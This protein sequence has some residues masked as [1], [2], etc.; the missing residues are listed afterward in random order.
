MKYYG[1][2]RMKINYV[3]STDVLVIGGGGAG[4][5]A[6]IKAGEAGA[7]VLLVTKCRFGYTGA[8]FYPG[9]EGWGINAITHEGDSVDYFYDEIIEAGAGATDRKLAR[10]LVEQSTERFHEMENYG[11]EFGKDKNGRYNSVIS[12]FGK[13]VRGACANLEKIK[14]ALWEQMMK[15]GVRIRS[16]INI[17][18]LVVDNGLCIGAVGFDEMDA[19]MFINAKSTVIATGGG[20][21]LFKYSLATP[22]QT[23]DGYIMAIEAGARLANLEFIQFIPGLTWPTKKL[24]FQEKNLDTFPQIKNRFGED[25]LPKYLPKGITVEECL[26]ERAKHGPFTSA[27]ISKYFDIALYEEWQKG[28]VTN[29]GGIHFR[30]DSSVLDDERWIITSW[31]EWMKSRNVDVVHEGFD[32]IPHAQC[33]NG[34]IY[35]DENANVGIKGLFAA[36]ETAGGPHGADRLG[37]N[38]QAATQVYGAIAGINAAQWAKDRTLAK[39]DAVDIISRLHS[40]FDTGQGGVVDIDACISEIKEIMWQCGAIVRSEE[41]IAEGLKRISDLQ[42]SFNPWEHYTKNI[43]TKKASGLYSRINLSKI[44]LEVM[45]YRKESRGPHYRTDYPEKNSAFEGMIT[46]KKNGEGISLEL[47]KQ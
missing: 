40:R 33:F 8:S 17:I 26:V 3:H 5:K 30:Y 37:G 47:L 24:L 34:G 14:K 18:S 6:A 4:I 11:V 22:D 21:D 25:V 44:L 28:N 1:G 23:G 20:C 13:R 45:L 39:E 10:I 42:R 31:V 41:R 32:I 19:L 16:G 43:N 12:C 9:M 15:N 46:V 27:A 35:I 29:S 36:G 38:A 2:M 7:E